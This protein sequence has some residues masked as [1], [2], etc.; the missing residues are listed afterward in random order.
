MSLELKELSEDNFETKFNECIAKL[1]Q[2][3]LIQKLK[4]F[5]TKSVLYSK[6]RN[7]HF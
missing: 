2:V 3:W 4:R 6:I 7:V 1:I 5:F